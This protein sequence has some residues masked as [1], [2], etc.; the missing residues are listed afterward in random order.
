VRINEFLPL[1]DWDEVANQ[2]VELIGPKHTPIGN[3]TLDFYGYN[4]GGDRIS[5]GP[6]YV[7]KLP[8]AAAIGGTPKLASG[9]VDKG[10]G[11]YVLGNSAVANRDIWLFP[12]EDDENGD[13]Q[14]IYLDGA[15]GKEYGAIALKRSMGAYADAIIWGGG[16]AKKST[17]VY[18]SLTVQSFVDEGFKIIDSVAR[19]GQALGYTYKSDTQQQWRNLPSAYTT[20]GAYNHYSQNVAIPYVSS[21]SEPATPPEIG[22]SIVDMIISDDSTEVELIFKLWSTNGIKVDASDFT[23][24]ID[25][26]LT[27]DFAEPTRHE[28]IG[29]TITAEADGSE[30]AYSVILDLSESDSARFFK[31]IAVPTL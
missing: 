11:F 4:F 24:Y 12:D 8:A 25:S 1:G 13:S 14:D 31:V 2:F 10:W 28:I 9:E 29:E 22:I 16:T 27:V 20:P 21:S 23:W 7:A 18:N 30:A 17:G 26:A 15:F 6:E 3:W 19:D 5:S